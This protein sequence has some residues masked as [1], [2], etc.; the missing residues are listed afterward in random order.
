M[1]FTE[2]GTLNTVKVQKS[3]FDNDI[4][5]AL[6]FRKLDIPLICSMPILFKRLI[7]I[8]KVT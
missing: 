4:Y 6:L 1:E 3:K 7:R 5:G 2:G 8:T